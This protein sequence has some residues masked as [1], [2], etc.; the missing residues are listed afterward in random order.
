MAESESTRD[1]GFVER[2]NIEL[3][4]AERYRLFLSLICIDLSSVRGFSQPQDSDILEHLADSLQKKV[5]VCDVVS[6]LSHGCLAILSPE[7]NREGA[8]VAARRAT[9]TVRDEL[10]RMTGKSLPNTIPLEIASYPDAA[11]VRTVPQLLE[12]AIS[13]SSN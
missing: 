8:E 4:R 9:L 12:L 6:A 5:R 10:N 2:A 13:K 7:T 11:G 3:E 1:E